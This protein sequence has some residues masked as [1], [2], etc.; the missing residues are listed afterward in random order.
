M[1]FTV[2]REKDGMMLSK[3][4]LQVGGMPPWAVKQVINK[5]D[6]RINNLR[7]SDDCRVCE[8]Q[9]IRVYWSKEALASQKQS[10]P[11]VPIVFE[12][13]HVLVINKPQGLQS[14]NEEN[15]L[16]G[17]SALTRVL[18]AKHK[19]TRFGFVIGSMFRPAVCCCSRKM[20]HPTRPRLKHLRSEPWR[21][22]I[23]A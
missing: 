3:L 19:P 16:I 23:P 7:I 5:R 11:T 13:E 20:K 14:Q 4:L 6:V 15:P 12:D 2:T 21:N 8:G 1:Q 18:S 10:K 9:E 22:T 17:D